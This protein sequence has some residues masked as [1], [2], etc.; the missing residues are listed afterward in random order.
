M[1]NINNVESEYLIN[2]ETEKAYV[3]ID[4]YTRWNAMAPEQRHGW[5]EAN[6]EHLTFSREDA[7]E[8]LER[9]IYR[10][11]SDDGYEGMA[12]DGFQMITDEHLNRMMDVL[13]DI[14]RGPVFSVFEEFGEMIDPTIDVDTYV[15][16]K[17]DKPMA[18]N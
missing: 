2:V 11:V 18:K 1:K 6:Q 9:M 16:I 8:G 10:L 17:E 4:V 5:Y 14:T 15:I 12:K 7:R 13:D 3:K